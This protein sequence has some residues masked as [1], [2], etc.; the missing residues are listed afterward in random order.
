M[1]VLREYRCT[2]HDHEFE[3]QEE[4][5]A[6]PY[7]CHPKF[8]VQEFRTPFA[9]GTPTGSTIDR[10]QRAV[11]DDYGLTDMRNDRDSS[12][13]SQTRKESGGM[14]R[15]GSGRNVREYR[16]EQ[17]PTWAPGI[18]KPSPGWSKTGE[19]PRFE[20][21]RSGLK[22]PGGI[23]ATQPQLDVAKRSLRSNTRVEASWNQK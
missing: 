13:M 16:P 3:S 21:N 7:G 18:F 14:R 1:A 11:A 17:V 9:I 20:W 2:A 23:S 15:I 10:L 6:C 19:V 8:V 12:V 4:R 22:G 5:P